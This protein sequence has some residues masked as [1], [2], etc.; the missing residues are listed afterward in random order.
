MRVVTKDS[1]RAFRLDRRTD[2]G[3]FRP[4]YVPIGLILLTVAGVVMAAASA[5]R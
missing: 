1:E 2:A 3:P 4:Y 5:P